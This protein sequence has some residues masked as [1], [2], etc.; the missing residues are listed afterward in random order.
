MIDNSEIILH[1]SGGTTIVGKDAILWYKAIHLLEALKLYSKSGI[2]VTRIVTPA[3]MLRAAGE[4]TKNTYK[5][6]QYTQAIRDLEVWI[7]TMRT[8]LPVTDNTRDTP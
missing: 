6:G 5:R 8:A 3:L 2:Q 1:K 4:V 7:A